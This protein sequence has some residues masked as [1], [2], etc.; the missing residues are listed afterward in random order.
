MEGQP[1]ECVELLSHLFI[2]NIIF[3]RN[4]ALLSENSISHVLNLTTRE[5][6]I[7]LPN[8]QYKNIP[9]QDT[10]SMD[11][12]ETNFFEA[13]EFINSAK[14]GERVL[15]HCAAGVSRASTMCIAYLMFHKEFNLET[16]H[17]Y[18]KERRPVIHP[19][20][21]FWEHLFKLETSLF[22]TKNL[23]F[24]SELSRALISGHPKTIFEIM[25]ALGYDDPLPSFHIQFKIQEEAKSI[26]ESKYGRAC[27]DYTMDAGC[28]G[29]MKLHKVERYL[30]RDWEWLEELAHAYFKEKKAAKIESEKK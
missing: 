24:N 9:L 12:S 16:A 25:E 18:V 30:P 28:A 29:I 27:E 22:T 4:S 21:G 2:G 20:R 3:A 19:N 23:P 1:G 8:V 10:C 11:I 6:K 15:V 17:R 7:T 13:F 5:V 26:Y 14:E